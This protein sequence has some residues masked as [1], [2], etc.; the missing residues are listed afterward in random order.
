MKNKS[1]LVSGLLG[2]LLAFSAG[3]ARGQDDDSV[4]GAV[5]EAK[6][7][8][9]QARVAIKKGNDHSADLSISE[10]SPYLKSVVSAVKQGS[11]SW[12]LALAALEKAEECETK[13]LSSS[14][15]DKNLELFAKANARLAVAQVNVL[16]VSLA[17]VEALYN[18]KTETL[19]ILEEAMDDAVEAAQRMKELCDL[20]N[21]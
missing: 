14:V 3:T 18:G 9:A 1:W 17:Y 11:A 7:A 2:V 12:K 10:D 8:V 4:L 6:K 13:L 20:L 15:K 5:A 16:E 21:M 19:G